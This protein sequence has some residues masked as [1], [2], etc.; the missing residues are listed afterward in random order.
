MV[1]IGFKKFILV[2]V[3]VKARIA[4]PRYRVLL[5]VM[6][7]IGFKKFILVMVA[8]KARIINPRYRDSHS[9]K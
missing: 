7:V 8:V 2:M 6:V 9:L 5:V 3:A 4:N 1:V